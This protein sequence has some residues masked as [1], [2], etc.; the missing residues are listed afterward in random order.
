VR[1]HTPALSPV[2]IQPCHGGQRTFGR[3]E[4]ERIS[5]RRMIGHLLAAKPAVSG[6]DG[7]PSPLPCRSRPG[8]SSLRWLLCCHFGCGSTEGADRSEED[9]VYRSRGG[10]A[11]PAHRYAPF[12]PIRVDSLTPHYIPRGESPHT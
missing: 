1:A 6:Y 9:R 8:R 7:Y 4:D 3:E 11:S 5:T 12:C 2:H 10:S